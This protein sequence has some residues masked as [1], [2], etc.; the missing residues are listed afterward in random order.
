MQPVVNVFTLIIFLGVIQGVLLGVFFLT[1]GSEQPVANRMLGLLLLSLAMVTFE[2][3][4]QYSGFITRAIHLV[5]FSEPL[6]FAIGPFAYLS[7]YGATR[8]LERL[9]KK[10]YLH[11]L[12]MVLYAI[13]CIW[14]F[15]QP[16]A[17]KYDSYLDAYQP[18][19]AYIPV[20]LHISP[21]PLGLREI[22]NELTL[23]H[24]FIYSTLSVVTVR[25]AFKRNGLPFLSRDD[26]E[27]SM[28][29]TMS[30]QF[31]IIVVAVFVVKAGFQH[32][33]GDYIIATVTTVF[34]YTV[35][36]VV[37]RDSAFFATHAKH[38]PRPKYEK[39][40][41]TSEMSRSLIARLEAL[42]EADKPHLD[43]GVSL[44]DLSRRL[45]VSPHHLSQV[46]NAELGQTF[47]EF[48]ATHRVEEAKRIL[49]GPDAATLRI[50][51][52]AESVGYYS[53]SAFNTAF[54]KLT[55]RTPSQYRDSRSS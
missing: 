27:L 37:V 18:D 44:P 46:L 4:M 12:P 34:I 38:E 26:A 16:A 23:L 55:G 24:L 28:L 1:R 3:L 49:S 21:D 30:L 39:S 45:G 6:N 42:M 22:V 36:G 5:N 14:F 41:L 11:L 40:S 9:P 50:E 43:N 15:I 52:V 35:G 19:L 7:F 20:T 13:Y 2:I 10:Q 51:D 33:L 29:R 54:K 17:Y 53:K 25:N 47:F 32:D 8:H 31:V 48:I